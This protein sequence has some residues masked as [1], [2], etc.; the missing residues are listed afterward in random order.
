MPKPGDNV[1]IETLKP[2]FRGPM[3]TPGSAE[4]EASRVIWN[5]MI[6]RKPAAIARCNGPADVKAAIRF[7]ADQNI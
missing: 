2:T 1:N 3:L 7:A 6:D 5:A 4:Y